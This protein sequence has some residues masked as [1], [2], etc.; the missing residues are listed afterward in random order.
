MGDN[1]GS[2]L[3]SRNMA[4]V[5]VT[6]GTGNL[7]R[8]V[9]RK[10]VERRDQPVILTRNAHSEVPA[11]AR[12]LIGDLAMQSDLDAATRSVDSI[13]HCASKPTQA[14]QD[15][16]GT[17]SLLESAGRNGVRRFVYISIV[18]VDR[19]SAPY[20]QTKYEVEKLSRTPTYLP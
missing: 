10:V 15:I 12:L 7:G 17:R 16:E 6:G 18:G 11:G 13:I 14:S 8:V 3:D 5:L 19:P 2:I 1:N 4:T 9:V 20:Y